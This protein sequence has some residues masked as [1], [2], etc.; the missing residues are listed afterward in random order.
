LP[1]PEIVTQRLKLT[2]LDPRDAAAFFRYRSDAEVCRYQSWA[3][4][5]VDDALSFI[6]ELQSVAFD[7]QGTWFQLAVRLREADLLIGDIG[8]HFPVDQPGQVEIGF[9]V[10]P[11]H[12][13]RGLGTEAVRGLLDH[14]FGPLGKHRVFASV[15]PRNEAS[16][17]LLRSVGM[18]QEAHFRESLWLKEEWVDDLVFGI[19]ESE[20]AAARHPHAG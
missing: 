13:R 7:T 6:T 9:T 18:R 8:V 17:A 10:A 14:I 20:W 1:G 5:S 19:L 11:G 16:I 15:D 2:P 4:G 12:Q 3:P